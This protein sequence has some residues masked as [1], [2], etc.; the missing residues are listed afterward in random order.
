MPV[1]EEDVRSFH[2][3][4]LNRISCGSADCDLEDLLD[5]W[6]AQNPDPVQQ[7]QDL[8]AIKEAIAEWKAGDE[9]LPADDAI[10]AIREAHQL[11][12]KS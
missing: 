9:G 4:A 6:R 10:A 12:L 1:T 8:L 3:F 5:E 2:Q 11:S 7:R